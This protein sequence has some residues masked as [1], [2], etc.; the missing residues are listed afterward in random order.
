MSILGILFLI[1]TFVMVFGEFILDTAQY[2]ADASAKR[3][4]Q[5]AVKRIEKEE[6]A[7][8]NEQILVEDLRA[9]YKDGY[10]ERRFT[11]RGYKYAPPAL[12]ED[13]AEP[14]GL[15]SS[16]N[17]IATWVRCVNEKGQITPIYIESKV[18]AYP[19]P[20]EVDYLSGQVIFLDSDPTVVL[21]KVS[22]SLSSEVP[23]EVK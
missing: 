8:S 4:A 14:N 6:R 16:K 10:G 21:E 9:G 18:T 2:M 7:R 23:T 5:K 19:F 1:F 12:S 20:I 13:E 17:S 3:S 15:Y 11:R 22:P